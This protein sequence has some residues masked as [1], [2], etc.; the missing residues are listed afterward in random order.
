MT[1]G[2]QA[3]TN[4]DVLSEQEKIVDK[5]AQE[6]GLSLTA[7]MGIV[8]GSNVSTVPEQEEAFMD[9][10]VRTY[11]DMASFKRILAENTHEEAHDGP[12]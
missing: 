12:D 6:S 7:A 10:I 5:F 2:Y 9:N 4:K 3:N 8:A 1:G 11:G